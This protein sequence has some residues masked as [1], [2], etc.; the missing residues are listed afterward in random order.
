[1]GKFRAQ[2]KEAARP[3]GIP[4]KSLKLYADLVP[5]VIKT[6]FNLSLGQSVFPTCQ[7]R[8]TIVPV[9]KNVCTTTA[10]AS[11]QNLCAL[12]DK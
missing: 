7:S 11:T 12:R 4:A 9:P 3:D 6:L 1:M 10:K 5:S 2:H 8:V